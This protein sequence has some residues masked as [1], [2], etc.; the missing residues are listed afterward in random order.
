MRDQLLQLQEEAVR[1]GCDRHCVLAD[2]SL[3]PPVVS[4]AMSAAV[5]LFVVAV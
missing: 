2:A 1:A 3:V 4:P 5:C